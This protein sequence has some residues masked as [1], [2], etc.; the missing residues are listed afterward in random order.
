MTG[1][2]LT[3]ADDD[4]GSTEVTLS[5]DPTPVP[6]TAAETTVT[7]T[8]TLNADPFAP[9]DSREVTV[10]LGAAG[11]AATEG[12][13]YAA[14]PDFT[15]TIPGGATSGSAAFTLTPTD[16]DLAEGDETLSVTGA[17]AG[18]TVTGTELTITDDETEVDGSDAEREPLTRTGE[19]GGDDT[20]GDGDAG[21]RCVCAR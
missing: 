10:S 18:L 17:A 5:V 13:D 8:A 16:D 1:T 7:V 20:D 2:E 3:I 14:V 21:R 6:E 4:T 19:R 11:D 12:A 15:V 9:G